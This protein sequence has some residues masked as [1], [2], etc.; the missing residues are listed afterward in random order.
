MECDEESGSNDMD[1]Y[2]ERF[3]ERIG[4]NVKTICVLDALPGD[5]KTFWIT[6]SL[7]GGLCVKVDIEVLK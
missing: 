4:D 6:S 1:Y 5:Y 7:R 3:K 2:L